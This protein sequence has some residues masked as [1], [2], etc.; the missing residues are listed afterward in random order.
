M[1]FRRR[2]GVEPRYRADMRLGVMTGG[3]DC[4]GLNAVLRAVVRR[5][6]RD[7][8]DEVVGFLDGWNGVVE[9]RWVPMDVRA[10]RG[11]LP[12][13]GTVLGTSRTAPSLL[14]GGLEQALA[15]I[16][17][18]DVDTLVVVGGDGTL[19]AA[20]AFAELGG[21]VIGIPKTI[22][23]D[24]IDRL[25]TTAESHDRVMVVEVMGR[26]TGHVA[27]Q[28]GIA[29]GATVTLVPE[30]PF[31]IE[32][33]CDRLQRRHAR[34]RYASI[35]VTAEGARPAPGTLDVPPVELDVWG[36]P[37]LGGVGSLLASEIAER[38]GF[39][40]RVTVLGHVQ[41]GGTPTAYDRVLCSRF[42]VAA[43]DAAHDGAND[44]MVALRSDR[45]EVV[46]LTEVVG[47]E[48]AVAEELL[49]VARVF[50]S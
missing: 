28:A 11:L 24:L 20:H 39:E 30:R 12:R 2:V 16:R 45:I 9:G 38:T 46:P 13:G 14:D 40:T 35:V 50:F 18:L 42:G 23:N 31:D 1:R 37:K 22:D 33:I 5:A 8:D 32:Q 3:G 25:H 17:E 6:V 44:H 29:G 48:K 43:V 36:R 10:T 21:S 47:R 49:D 7:H 34:G 26:H 4:P 19:G 27:V 15:T 41:R